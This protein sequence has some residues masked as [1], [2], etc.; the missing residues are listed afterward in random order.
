[1]GVGEG[2]T[3]SALLFS[4]FLTIF[5]WLPPVFLDCTLLEG[6]DLYLLVVFKYQQLCLAY[7][8]RQWANV[9]WINEY[10]KRTLS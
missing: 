5:C 6:T 10:I 4:H 3:G 2:P 8:S 1:M 7:I 9:C